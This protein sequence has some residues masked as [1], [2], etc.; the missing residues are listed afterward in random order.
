[1]SRVQIDL[2]AP[3]LEVFREDAVCSLSIAVSFF[4]WLYIVAEAREVRKADSEHAAR[5]LWWERR[6]VS[7]ER[8]MHGAAT[9]R[10]R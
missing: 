10:L 8:E 5:M 1:M 4:C 6:A 9:E 7:L 3:P 2:L